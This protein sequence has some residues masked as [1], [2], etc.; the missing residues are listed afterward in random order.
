VSRWSTDVLNVHCGPEGALALTR[1]GW[2]QRFGSAGEYP[3]AAGGTRWAAGVAGL[4]AALA[5][6]P[7]MPVRVVLANR[8][9]Q[10][11]VMPW[12]D[13]LHG[14]DEYRA[15]AQLEFAGAY[16][17]LADGWTITLSDEEPGRARLAAAIPGDLLTAIKE[18]VAA[19]RV[20]L[21]GVS[22][23]LTIA[24]GLWPLAESDAP[25][26]LVAVEPGQLCFAVHGDGN[27]RWV[28][29]LRS[30][31]DWANRLPQLL[32]EERHLAHLDLT[33]EATRVFAPEANRDDLAT[34]HSHGF[35]GMEVTAKL[36]FSLDGDIKYL[37]AWCA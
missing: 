11:R 5:E 29:Q 26:C 9:A 22:P 33:P 12:H 35:A 7:G 18:V 30:D 21:L 28:R 1:L 17:S 23:A 2:R 31:A 10:F 24:A 13:H 19:Q 15:L 34:L 32:D 4:A 16:G 3:Q 25:Q 6:H 36:G 8:L 27:W 20:R 14:D 37:T